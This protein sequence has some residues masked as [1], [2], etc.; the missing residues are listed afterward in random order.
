VILDTT[1]SMTDSCSSSVTGTGSN[2]QKLDCAKAGM[3]ALLQALWPCNSTLTTGG[4]A[5]TNTGGQLGANVSAPVDEVGLEV[6]PAISG[7]PP[8]PAATTTD[9]QVD[10]TNYPSSKAGLQGHLPDVHA[11]HLQRHAGQ[12]RHSHERRVFRL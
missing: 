12:R 8:S 5:T 3:R 6:F 10:C 4:A 9:R 1:Q 2:P 11:V 7:N